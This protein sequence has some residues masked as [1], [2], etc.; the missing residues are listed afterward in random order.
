[1]HGSRKQLAS[2]VAVHDEGTKR[3]SSYIAK[4]WILELSAHAFVVQFKLW[5]Y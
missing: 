2:A 1:M 4:A 5:L 3:V